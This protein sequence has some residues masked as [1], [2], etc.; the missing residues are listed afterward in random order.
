MGGD[1][2]KTGQ[3]G[4]VAINLLTITNADNHCSS[5]QA[6]R[7]TALLLGEDLSLPTRLNFPQHLSGFTTRIP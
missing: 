7:A 5:G 1:I 6:Y 4:G 3:F 2:S